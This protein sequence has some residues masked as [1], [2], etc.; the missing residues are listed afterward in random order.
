MAD[1]RVRYEKRSFLLALEV[2]LVSK[3]WTGITY[4][5][6]YQ[7]DNPITNPQVD[8]RFPPS[9]FK[10]LELGGMGGKLFTRLVLVNAYMENEPRAET[11]VDDIMDFMD[12]T[13]V[14]IVDPS[15]STLGTLICPNSE[16][17]RGE[18]FPPI[19]ANPKLVRWRGAAQ[20][21]F[22]AFY[23]A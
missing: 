5:D 20:G 6:G 4:T 18:V 17:I 2:Y 15:G 21:P 10:D 16:K 19:M 1:G 13:C 14:N 12:L 8:V 11:I 3:G 22:E 7:S 9:S 23:P